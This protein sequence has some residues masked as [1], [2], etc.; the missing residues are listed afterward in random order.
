MTERS[1]KIVRV[2][3]GSLTQEGGGNDVLPHGTHLGLVSLSSLQDYL[4][5]P[6]ERSKWLGRDGGSSSAG[7]RPSEILWQLPAG[8]HFDGGASPV[9]PHLMKTARCLSTCL[10][11]PLTRH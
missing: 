10:S 6:R 7:T 5:T 1:S 2:R 4:H 11:L 3:P 8:R 9:L